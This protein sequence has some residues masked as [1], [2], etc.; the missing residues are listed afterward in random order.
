MLFVT[1][2]AWMLWKDFFKL[3]FQI[4]G[5]L[6]TEGWRE[7]LRVSQRVRNWNRQQERQSGA[8][9]K[10]ACETKVSWQSSPRSA[11]HSRKINWSC[12]CFCF[13]SARI[14]SRLQRNSCSLTS[15][16]LL[17]DYTRSHNQD[18]HSALA[19]AAPTAASRLF[20]A[21]SVSRAVHR[22]RCV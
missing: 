3:S 22:V 19:R 14:T 11:A 20:G 1:N 2:T 6:E 13:F 9:S 16:G 4:K 7:R 10:R 21:L 17:R 12:F 15:P 5:W 8:R 18:K